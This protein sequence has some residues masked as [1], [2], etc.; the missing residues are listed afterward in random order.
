MSTAQKGQRWAKFLLLNFGGSV[1]W[2]IDLDKFLDDGGN[3]DTAAD[4][5]ELAP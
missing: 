3:P 1:E 5:A 2:A 4:F